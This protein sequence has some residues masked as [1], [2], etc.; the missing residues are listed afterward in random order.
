VDAGDGDCRGA[1]QHHAAEQRVA[2]PE[3]IPGQTAQRAANHH[4]QVAERHDRRKRRPRHPPLAHDRRQRHA[5][6]LIVEAVEDDG[7]RREEDE[8]L[9]IAGPSPVVQQTVDVERRR[10]RC[11]H[12]SAIFSQILLAGTGGAPRTADDRGGAYKI[13]GWRDRHDQ[14]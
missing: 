8:P 11:R 10:V 6:Q 9:L 4:P 2:A 12:A 14:Q 7:Q 3:A 5:E 1:E 13:A